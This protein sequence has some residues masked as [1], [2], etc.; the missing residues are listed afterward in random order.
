MFRDV[1][2]ESYLFGRYMLICISSF[3][4]RSM[5][6]FS[7]TSSALEFDL[8]ALHLLSIIHSFHA[9]ILQKKFY[10]QLSANDQSEI[11]FLQTYE[12]DQLQYYEAYHDIFL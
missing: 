3:F 5:Y 12:Y 11:Q 8:V 2:F 6:I 4:N 1:I 10:L 7:D 9:M